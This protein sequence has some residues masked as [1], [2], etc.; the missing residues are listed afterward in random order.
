MIVDV[1]AA[2][3]VPPRLVQRIR[4]YAGRFQC[5]IFTRFVNR[6]GSLFRRKLKQRCCAP[7]SEDVELLISP[8]E[9]D[10]VLEKTGYG[11]KP[12]DLKKLHQRGIKRLTVCGLDTDACVLG[13][14]F[15]LFDAGFDC[16]VKKDL[17]WSSTGLHQEGLRIIEEQFPQPK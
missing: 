5:R 7:G 17:C 6:P 9:D 13:V 4:Q 11:L 10:L 15:S 1:Q 12:T 2:F 3:D 8:R 16:W 14:M